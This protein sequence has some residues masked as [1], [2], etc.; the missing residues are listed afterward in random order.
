MSHPLP[1]GAF[2]IVPDGVQALADEL[3]A[4]AAELTE[5]VERTRS[6]AGSFPDALGGI[7]GWTAGATA[8][9]WA[10]LYEL[11][12]SRTDEL[13]ATLAAAAAAYLAEDAWL[14]GSLG[15]GRRPR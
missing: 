1:G 9:S 6:A 7:E 5:D 13:A 15:S 4:L 3:A 8:T 10:C 11:I 14:A 2:T 12:V